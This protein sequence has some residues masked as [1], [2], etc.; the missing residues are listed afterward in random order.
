MVKRIQ[1]EITLS[2]S[3][4]HDFVRIIYYV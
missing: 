2:I 4:R 3:Q 1:R